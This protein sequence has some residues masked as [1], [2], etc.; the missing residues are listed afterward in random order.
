MQLLREYS[1]S[2]FFHLLYIHIYVEM[3]CHLPN[4]RVA[5]YHALSLGL[6]QPSPE[7]STIEKCPETDNSS[8]SQIE[9]LMLR[10]TSAGGSDVLIY[11][12]YVWSMTLV[13]FICLP[14]GGAKK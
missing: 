8:D 14:T 5:M 3:I 2:D 6:N 7:V 11:P 12:I 4:S 9:I 10:D 13:E 1:L